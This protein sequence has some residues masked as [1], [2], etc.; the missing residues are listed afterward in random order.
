VHYF[1]RTGN[2]Q[3]NRKAIEESFRLFFDPKA[4][5]NPQDLS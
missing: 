5:K 3:E 4:V 1:D 2:T